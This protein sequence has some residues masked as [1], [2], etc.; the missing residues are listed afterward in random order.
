MDKDD[1]YGLLRNIV[2]VRNSRRMLKRGYKLR[3]IADMQ[4]SELMEK[5][6]LC[7]EKATLLGSSVRLAQRVSTESFK[8]VGTSMRSGADIYRH[9]ASKFTG[10]EVEQLWVVLLNGKHTI[11]DTIMVSQGTLTS[12]PVNPREVFRPAIM[13]AAASIVLVHNHPSGDPEPSLDDLEITNRLVQVGELVG[14]RVLDHVIVGSAAYV[15]LSD[16]GVMSR[17]G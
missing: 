6:G 5:Y 2:G 13:K 9:F 1:V 8:I 3:E 16:R 7:E 10:L 12:A 14:I 4:V 11:K 15:S 17:R